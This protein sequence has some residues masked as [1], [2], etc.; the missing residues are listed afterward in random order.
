MTIKH[1]VGIG[2]LISFVILSLILG[3]KIYLGISAT[4]IALAVKISFITVFVLSLLLVGALSSLGIYYLAMKTT[5][6]AI[7]KNI[8]TNEK[9]Q[10]LS[11]ELAKKALETMANI[12]NN[13]HPTP[14]VNL[15]LPQAKLSDGKEE[16][17][18]EENVVNLHKWEKG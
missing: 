4:D 5:A 12:S 15:S 2:I 13:N 17:Q 9:T 1:F 14:V 6:S 8:N 3:Y 18:K 7:T 16:E 10:E 11:A